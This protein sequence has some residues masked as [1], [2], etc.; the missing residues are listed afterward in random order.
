MSSNRPRVVIPGDEPLQIGQSAHLD[1][2]R[3]VADVVLHSDCPSSTEEQ[4]ERMAGA[5]LMINSRGHVHWS[6]ELLGQLTDLNMITTCSIGTDAIDL[7]AA[8]DLGIVVSNIPG[9]TAPVVA[10][11]ALCLLLAAAR[12]VAY[13]TSS[14]R[15]G[16][17][18]QRY[19]VFLAGKTLGIIGTGSIGAYFA[20]LARAIGMRVIAWTYNPSPERASELGIEFVSLDELLSMSD[21]VS[22]HVKLTDDSRDL[23]GARELAL[24]K[25]G[26]ILVNTARGPIVDR[27]A[28]VDALNSG[29]LGGAGLDVYN[30][31]PIVADDPLLQCEQ[32]VL[33]P[34]N[35]DQTPEGVEI[36]NGGAVD[37][38]LAYLDGAPQ[39]VVT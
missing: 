33:T 15:T 28:L 23:L 35:A 36:L 7:D 32:V 10:E 14:I 29:H 1:R 2:L 9:R 11:H 16:A 30:K 39:N 22:V 21:A 25:P 6:R 13:H 37:N 17:W 3:E 20:R 24:M 18:S 27:Q 34:H 5:A 8:R 4:L 19:S 38:V 26:S 31:E 12:R